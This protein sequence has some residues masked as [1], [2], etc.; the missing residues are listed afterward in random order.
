VQD[1]YGRVERGREFSNV[2]CRRLRS[3]APVRRIQY[4]VV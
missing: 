2:R 3:G 1:V 4:V